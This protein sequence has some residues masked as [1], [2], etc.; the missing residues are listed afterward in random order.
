MDTKK[1]L[2]V[3]AFIALISEGAYA[4]VYDV[5]TYG[6]STASTDNS[7]AIQA[8]INAAQTAQGGEVYIPEMYRCASGLV[9]SGANNMTLRGDADRSGLYFEGA[10]PVTDAIAII[11]SSKVEISGLRLLGSS[12][13]PTVSRL[14]SIY[15][16]SYVRIDRNFL[17]GANR[18]PGTGPTAAVAVLGAGT[19]DVRIADNEFWGNGELAQVKGYDIVNWASA[20]SS[21][22]F[23]TDNRIAGGNAEVSIA[24]FD[25]SNVQIDRNYVDQ[26]NKTAGNNNDGYGILMYN[27]H[28]PVSRGTISGNMI[29]NSAGS[30]IY[31][32][33][34]SAG[35]RDFGIFNNSILDTAKQQND[36]TLPVGGISINGAGQVLISGNRIDTSG[37][38]GIEIT[39]TNT[40][41]V[42][43]N[44][45]TSSGRYGIRLR[46]AVTA[47]TLTGNRLV[48]NTAGAYSI[49]GAAAPLLSANRMTAGAIQGQAT[50][51]SGT[52]TVS[53]SEVQAGDRIR[54]SHLTNAGVP[55]IAA[56]SAI[57]AGV[58]FMIGSSSA[59]DQSTVLWE[60]VH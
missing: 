31:I 33:G 10:N 20:V 11:N 24:V 7:P 45:A 16:G 35:D 54:I 14:V 51:V 53:T 40:V 1:W 18:A 19:I 55:G 2:A 36:V 38:N 56:V 25:A 50:L 44:L 8:A 9:I 23:I 34:G 57:T 3:C 22:I 15:G 59:A 48:G 6:A 30:G 58:S 12:S 37:K 46:A 13:T 43:D 49:A 41:S 17:S 4:A 21:Q 29:R 27:A 60:I 5:R 39:G 28:T 47:A 32:A 26:N 52:A 42:T